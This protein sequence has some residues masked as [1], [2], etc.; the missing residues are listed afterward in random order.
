MTA[1]DTRHRPPDNYSAQDPV[2]VDS[3]RLATT[4]GDRD[5]S[6]FPGS[7]VLMFAVL[8]IKIKVTLDAALLSSERGS[9]QP[10]AGRRQ[11]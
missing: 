4:V 7:D 5:L 6:V 10:A 8:V 2:N 9:H 11:R 1:R 3:S